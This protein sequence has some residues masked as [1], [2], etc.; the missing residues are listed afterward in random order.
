ME[1][2]MLMNQILRSQGISESEY[3]DLRPRAPMAFPP[4]PNGAGELPPYIDHTILRA[5]ATPQDI[6]KLCGEA[7][8]YKFASVCINPVYVNQASREL[9]GS[10]VKVCTVI[11]FPLGATMPGCKEGEARIALDDGADEIDMVIQIGLLKAG[12]LDDVRD[13]IVRVKDACA[14]KVLKVI[15]ENTYLTNDEKVLACILCK[16]AGADYVKTSTGFGPGGATVE[17]V[18]LMREVVGPYYGVKAAGG[19]RNAETALAMVA[20]GATR[21]GASA[22]VAIVSGQ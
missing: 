18:K 13:E 22:G 2:K 6:S 3:N 14:D 8:E 21:I 7:K 19:I 20:A 16:L 11:G 1:L 10:P 5:D 12:E 4:P 9:Q 15:I 17:D